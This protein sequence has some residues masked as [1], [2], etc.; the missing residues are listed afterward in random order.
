MGDFKWCSDPSL[1]AAAMSSG[2]K[3]EGEWVFT[4]YYNI[5]IPIATSLTEHDL[6]RLFTADAPRLA[7]PGLRIPFG[8]RHEW[9]L[10]TWEESSSLTRLADGVSRPTLVLSLIIDKV[11]ADATSYLAVIVDTVRLARATRMMT[12]KN[13]SIVTGLLSSI[14][15][16]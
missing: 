9:S 7:N 14:L 15:L 13:S 2:A 4:D 8:D 5:R 16:P 12:C 11:I 1:A 6:R 10:M 3:F